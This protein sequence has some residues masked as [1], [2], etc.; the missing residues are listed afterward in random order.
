MAS[1]S[2][3]ILHH[4]EIPE[5]H[6]PVNEIFYSIQGEGFHHGCPAF[7]I[8]F[9]GCDIGC[10]WCDSKDGWSVEE[11]HFMPVEHIVNEAVSSDIGMVIITGG[12]PLIYN[13]QNLTEKLNQNKKKIH[14]ETSGAYPLFASF[15]W[16]TLSPKKV[17]LPLESYYSLANELKI[18]VNDE[19]DLNFAQS[20]AK[21]I[22]TAC[23]LFLQPQWNQLKIMLPKIMD[24]IKANPEWRLSLQNH[25]FLG[26]K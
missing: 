9:A 15:D 23:H 25:K 26:I 19:S 17:K 24:F 6:I 16:L 21:K 10:I 8:R 4:L 20:Q 2:T 5:N 14:I 7:F 22:G 3:S 11:S 12:E 13:L 1:D 18:I